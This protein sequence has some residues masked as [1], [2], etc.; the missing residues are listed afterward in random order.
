MA[1]C[2][3]L[4]PARTLPATI[5]YDKASNATLPL[6]DSSTDAEGN[7]DES[8]EGPVNPPS[9][10]IIVARKSFAN[11]KSRSFCSRRHPNVLNQSS[12]NPSPLLAAI[13]RSETSGNAASVKN[14]RGHRN[15]KGKSVERAR[16]VAS[17]CSSPNNMSSPAR[18]LGRTP[19]AIGCATIPRS[20]E[21]GCRTTT[22]GRAGERQFQLRCKPCG[23]EVEE[24][25]ESGQMR[26]FWKRRREVEEKY[27]KLVC[28][29]EIEETAELGL[30]MRK[31]KKGKPEKV[32]EMVT[33]LRLYYQSVKAL[34]VEQK[35]CEQEDLIFEYK[36]KL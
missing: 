20:P 36:Q 27:R 9:S 34:L 25:M 12:S 24:R 17:P 10:F 7:V 15:T 11:K 31:T 8:N 13:H 32:E 18:V 1:D 29:L 33:G 19:K 30:R 16:R 14:N 2:H 6:P 23:R 28:D 4:A 5:A 35:I 22:H 21:V 26:E 3:A